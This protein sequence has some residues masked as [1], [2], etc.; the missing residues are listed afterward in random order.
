MLQASLNNATLHNAASDPPVKERE[1]VE[2]E[3]MSRKRHMAKQQENKC[4]YRP[5]AEKMI[6]AATIVE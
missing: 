1:V 4:C 3:K 2:E 5:K 6:R